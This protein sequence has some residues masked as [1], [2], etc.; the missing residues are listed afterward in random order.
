M[1]RFK[2]IIFFFLGG[3]SHESVHDFAVKMVFHKNAQTLV[4]VYVSCSTLLGN[5]P[6]IKY[7]TPS[8][9]GCSYNKHNVE[10]Q[11]N[12]FFF[13]GGGGSH[14]SV[15]DFAAKTVVTAVFII[16]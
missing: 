9:Q 7:Q 6:N 16:S 5:A 13:G 14:E 2:Q 15:H 8:S 12:K 4:I 3:G 1:L 10:V 11:A